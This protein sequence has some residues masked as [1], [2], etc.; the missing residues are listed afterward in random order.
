MDFEEF[1]LRGNIA[2]CE[3]SRATV[4]TGSRPR[5]CCSFAGGRGELDGRGTYGSDCRFCFTVHQGL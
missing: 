2:A 4:V 1:Y 3:A 5:H